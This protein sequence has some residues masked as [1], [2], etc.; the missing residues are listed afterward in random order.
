MHILDVELAALRDC[1]DTGRITATVT[2]LTDAGSMNIQASAA[3]KRGGDRRSLVETLMQDVIR[4]IRF[5][6]EMRTGDTRITLAP[7]ALDR[8][9]QQG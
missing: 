6:P 1:P 5:M 8:A 9:V 4:Q 7:G 3:Q 2:L